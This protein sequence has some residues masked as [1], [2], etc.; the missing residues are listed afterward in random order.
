MTI[1]DFTLLDI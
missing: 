1:A